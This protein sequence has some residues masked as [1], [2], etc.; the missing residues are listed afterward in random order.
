MGRSLGGSLEMSLPSSRMSPDVG[1]SKPA[2]IRSVVVFPQP[3]GPRKV[4]NSPRFTSRLKSSTALNP[5]SNILQM[6]LSSMMF[7]LLFSMLICS[8][9]FI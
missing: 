5:S 2:I 3:E 9:R 6:C 8:P 7:P 1:I 4:T